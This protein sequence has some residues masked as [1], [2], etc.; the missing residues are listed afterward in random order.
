MKLDQCLLPPQVMIR[1][2]ERV[3]VEM[4]LSFPKEKWR[5]LQGCIRR[6]TESGNFEDEEA[7][8]DWLLSGAWDKAKSDLCALH[9]TI[10]ETYFFREP[11]AFDLVRDY[12]REKMQDAEEN[13][14]IRIWSAGCCTG[15]EPYSIA[16]AL[17]QAVPGAFR[18]RVSILA[19]D[20]NSEHLQYARAGVYRQWSFRKTRAALQSQY[21][22]EHDDNR[23]RINDDIRDAVRFAELNLATARYPSVATDTH[24]MDIIFCRNVLM[25]FSKGQ[26]KKVIE[27]F[28]N[29]LVEG[30]W[31][32]VSPS[33][34]SSELFE[35]F[36]GVYYP[37]AI[38]FQKKAGSTRPGMPGSCVGATPAA[39]VAKNFEQAP[40]RSTASEARPEP[41]KPK[42]ITRKGRLPRQ[43]QG[44]AGLE[45]AGMAAAT[46]PAAKALANQGKFGEAM[47]LLEQALAAD[48][49]EADIYQAMAL[50]A[51]ESGDKDGAM[52]S[53]KRVL[54]L[55]PDF[56]LA[57]YLMGVLLSEQS[58]SGEAARQFRIANELLMTLADDE[59]VP[60]SD[61]LHAAYL[62]ESIHHHLLRGFDEFDTRLKYGRLDRDA[63]TA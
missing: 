52:Q 7:C 42:R 32:V 23:L 27:R 56:I 38:Y 57:H 51:L 17:K 29:C 25:Y 28:W 41:V 55:L 60:G 8:V 49:P 61:G 36:A 54:Y 14:R 2:M 59:I 24:L 63:A 48:P 45:G 31:L 9:M 46:V 21:F 34:A 53:L 58:R 10:G 43:S 20:I 37:D 44:T 50:V 12:V 6:M 35:G 39:R 15:E 47:Q 4:G 62:R 16:M 33:E 3:E 22:L 30:G 19:T 40:G 13:R 11:R 26:V 5:E 1:L 18:D